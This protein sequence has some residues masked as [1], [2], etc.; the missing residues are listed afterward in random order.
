MRTPTAIV[1]NIALEIAG[2][3]H[4]ISNSIGLALGSAWQGVNYFSQHCVHAVC[5]AFIVVQFS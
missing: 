5:I 2:T 1:I 3:V 4:S